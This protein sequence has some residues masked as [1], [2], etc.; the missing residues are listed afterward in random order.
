MTKEHAGKPIYFI[1]FFKKPG[2]DD[3][4][5]TII[6]S[7]AAVAV[8]VC[9]SFFSRDGYDNVGVFIWEL[10]KSIAIGLLTTL[11]YYTCKCLRILN[12]DKDFKRQLKTS[13]DKVIREAESMDSSH[14]NKNM[15][16]LT[17]IINNQ[18]KIGIFRPDLFLID[19]VGECKSILSVTESPIALWLD[20]TYLFF[21]TCQVANNITKPVPLY[22]ISYCKPVKKLYKSRSDISVFFDEGKKIREGWCAFNPESTDTIKALSQNLDSR[23]VRIYFMTRD[24]IKKNKGLVEWFVSTHDLAGI[25]LFIIDRNVLTRD[26]IE[27]HY[28]ELRKIMSVDDHLDFALRFYEKELWY[29][30]RNQTELHDITIGSSE[31]KVVKTVV[32]FLKELASLENSDLIYPNQFGRFDTEGFVLNEVKT[33]IILKK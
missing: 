8:M 18:I 17:E 22:S 31:E 7:I 27:T 4:R 28:K 2:R 32:S 33:Q 24:E 26:A 20:P 15:F 21:L 30:V 19:E 16:Y 1:K 9:Y 3:L 13:I 11:V 12:R 29:A 10:V 5:I 14:R 25:H 6:S 23:D